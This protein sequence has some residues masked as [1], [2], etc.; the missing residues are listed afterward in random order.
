MCSPKLDKGRTMTKP[1]LLPHKCILRDTP[2]TQ[3]VILVS[4]ALLLLALCCSR[5]AAA[6]DRLLKI[7]EGVKKEYGSLAGLTV[8][9]E[10]DVVTRSMAMLDDGIKSDL[11]AGFIHFKPPH[12]LRIEQESPRQELVIS[13]GNTLWWYI[14]EKK[15]VYRYPAG[16]LGQ[17]LKLLSDIFKG[18]KDVIDGFVVELTA[19]D[20]GGRHELKLTPNPPWPEIDF[21]HLSVS[22]K[23]STIRVVKLQNYLGGFTRFTLGDFKVEED[24]REDFFRFTAPDGVKVIQE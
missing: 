18:L 2:L 1:S 7:L 4:S 14:P 20:T 21:I 12:F 8:T 22:E 23:D 13:D 15:E 11:A 24:F 19:A 16:K 3:W 6:D 9:Y 10:R 17:E 5:A